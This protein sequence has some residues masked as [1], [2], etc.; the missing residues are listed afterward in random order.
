MRRRGLLAG[1]LALAG[2][3]LTGCGL[4]ERPYV[5]KR[6]W[7]L[8]VARAP[9]LPANPRGPVLLVR[10][11]QAAPGLAARGLRSLQ[12]DGSVRTDF[13]ENWAVPPAQGVDEA[14]R[15]WLAG[16]GRYA[17]V[18]APG[19]RL[20]ADIVLEASL[21]EL[22]AEPGNGKARA[23]MTV[24]LLDQ[25]AGPT[26]LSAQHVLNAEA[27][28]SSADAPSVARAMLEALEQ[29]LAA[30]EQALAAPASPARG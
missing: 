17:G 4:S 18:L 26:R 23:A 10:Q 5:Q 1:G 14:L 27:P 11:L 13:Y 20:A 25:R 24:V 21:T 16:C 22:V 29:L 7:P 30:V 2:C 9:L 3:G 6:D 15:A 8:T 28:L 12:P 19:S